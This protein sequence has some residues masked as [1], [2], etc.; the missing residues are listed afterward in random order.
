MDGN[1][2]SIGKD[3][4]RVI[5]SISLIKLSKTLVIPLVGIIS[6]G[7]S[8]LFSLDEPMPYHGLNCYLR[9]LVALHCRVPRKQILLFVN[10]CRDMSQNEV[11]GKN[12]R[13][14]V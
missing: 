4:G 9:S 3:Q 13:D 1:C 6:L 2:Q 10:Y 12:E 8:S 14:G 5:L 11:K 7:S